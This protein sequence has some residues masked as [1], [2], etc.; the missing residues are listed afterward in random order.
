VSA[1][2]WAHAVTPD[3]I[4]AQ[5]AAGWPDFH[6]EDFC[7]RCGRR[8][9]CW[10]ASRA[11]WAVARGDDHGGGIVCPSCFIELHEAATGAK[12]NWGLTVDA[13]SGDVRRGLITPEGGPS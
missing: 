8:N 1:P 3:T 11:A 5:R 10:S 12:V 9:P 2:G 13:D 4:V 6:P 7:H